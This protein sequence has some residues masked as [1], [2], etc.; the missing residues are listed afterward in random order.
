MTQKV[1][2]D[3]TENLG[4]DCVRWSDV[5]LSNRLNNPHV[6]KY[7]CR[8]VWKFIICLLNN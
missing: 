3:V 6:N 8:V 2:N 5:S 4:C 1:Y 7:F